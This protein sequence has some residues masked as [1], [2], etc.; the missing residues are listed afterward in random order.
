[1]KSSLD[2]DQ[3]NRP[4]FPGP[5]QVPAHQEESLT[6][7]A[8]T[9]SKWDPAS[10]LLLVPAGMYTHEMYTHENGVTNRTQGA[11]ILDSQLIRQL[12][13]IFRRVGN[14]NVPQPFLG[15]LQVWEAKEKKTRC[16]KKTGAV[17]LTG[18]GRLKRKKVSFQ[19]QN[20][21]LKKNLLIKSCML[22]I[23]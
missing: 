16:K 1:M 14:C 9:Q 17:L 18:V 8:V 23:Y 22:K 5:V 3:C 6:A 15:W 12:I 2:V 20:Y 21:F 11:E 10:A 13:A 7:P 4:V 19:K